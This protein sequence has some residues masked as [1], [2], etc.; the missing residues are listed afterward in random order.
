MRGEIS[1]C[2]SRQYKRFLRR[3]FYFTVH[4]FVLQQL[5][6]TFFEFVLQQAW[7]LGEKH[8]CLFLIA[9]ALQGLVWGKRRVWGWVILFLVHG[10]G[11][12]F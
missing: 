5:A 4:C 8:R 6:V 2:T 1:A 9:V 10:S 11:F 12:I 7:A 3:T